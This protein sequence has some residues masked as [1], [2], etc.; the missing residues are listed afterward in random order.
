MYRSNLFELR[1]LFEFWRFHIIQRDFR[2]NLFLFQRIFWAELR[3]YQWWFV[4]EGFEWR[5]IERQWRLRQKSW[6]KS[7]R[8]RPQAWQRKG[9]RTRQSE[10][11]TR[12]WGGEIEKKNFKKKISKKQTNINNLFKNIINSDFFYLVSPSLPVISTFVSA[13]GASLHRKSRACQDLIL[14]NFKI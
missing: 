5:H 11:R 13:P 9:S 7:Q 10:K 12:A 4:A 6:T 3:I 2:R 14:P 8:K 1:N